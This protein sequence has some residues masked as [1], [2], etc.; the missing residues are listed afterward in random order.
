MSNH[1]LSGPDLD[2]LAEAELFA[3]VLG[4]SGLDLVQTKGDNG[5]DE[6]LVVVYSS[7]NAS[8]PVSARGLTERSHTRS[9][10]TIEAV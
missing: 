7:P 10:S 4:P 8:S 6:F 3:G 1:Q 5:G 2:A 9:T